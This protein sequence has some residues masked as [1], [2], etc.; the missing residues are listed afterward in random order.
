MGGAVNEASAFLKSGCS[1]RV[2]SFP[3][4]ASRPHSPSSLAHT[5]HQS[6]TASPGFLAHVHPILPFSWSTLRIGCLVRIVLAVTS[7]PNFN[8]VLPL[9]APQHHTPTVQNASHKCYWNAPSPR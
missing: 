6:P 2:M 8:P 7:Y 9:G 1:Y 4:V 5:P 3:K